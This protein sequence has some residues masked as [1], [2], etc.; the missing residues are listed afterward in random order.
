M[1][2]ARVLP[3]ALFALSLSQPGVA[4][5]Q[6]EDRRLEG[7]VG[8]TN[9]SLPPPGLDVPDE[10]GDG[11]AILASAAIAVYVDI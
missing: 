8:F 5:I 4:Q 7:T 10:D 3:L 9:T 1:R 11:V 2:S 6:L